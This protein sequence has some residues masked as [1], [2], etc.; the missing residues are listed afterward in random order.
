[1]GGRGSGDRVLFD[2]WYRFDDGVVGCSDGMMEW[3]GWAKFGCL[4]EP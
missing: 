2:W 3:M 1:M 4:H